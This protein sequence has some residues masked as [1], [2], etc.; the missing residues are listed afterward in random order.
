MSPQPAVKLVQWHIAGAASLVAFASQNNT[1]VAV[2][3][4]AAALLAVPHFALPAAAVVL[5][6]GMGV[7][8]LEGPVV[9]QLHLTDI[10][11]LLFITRSLPALLRALRQPPAHVVLSFLFVGWGL[12]VTALAGVSM[13]PLFRIAVYLVAGCCVA[14]NAQARRL[15]EYSIVAYALIELTFSLPALP[16]R[17]FGVTAGDP[18]QFG[19]LMVVAATIVALRVR[20]LAIRV[21]LAGYLA[22][23]AFF[24]L[25][26]SIWFA[27]AAVAAVLLIRARGRLM[28]MAVP[29]IGAFVGLPL[30][31]Q[32]TEAAQLN[33]AS[34]QLRVTSMRNALADI[35]EHPVAGQ[36]WAYV[37]R[38]LMGPTE[39][40][41]A[42]YN[43][44]L[45]VAAC[46]G[47]V[48]LALFTAWLVLAARDLGRFDPLG[49]AVLTIMIAIGMSEMPVYAAS[50]LTLVFLLLISA[51]R[52]PAAP[53]VPA[54]PA[55]RSGLAGADRS[56]GVTQPALTPR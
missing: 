4:L 55:R 20:P 35:Q 7:A 56:A 21:P 52:D 29:A 40:G 19:G 9:G 22:A 37:N 17:L 32:I 11:L 41:V 18:G 48:G 13:T 34:L 46:T 8:A 5:M 3:A 24:S 45:Y 43:L 53:V 54:G 42:A 6:K 36:G 10:C 2:P 12:L 26:R 28:P 50:L 15:L 30:V 31:P 38:S 44:W 27:T 47:L 25:T 16:A 14:G 39:S 51:F 49:Y 23:G 1:L 33:A